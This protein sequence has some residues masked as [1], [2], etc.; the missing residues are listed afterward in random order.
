MSPEE[1][2]AVSEPALLQTLATS[3]LFAGAVTSEVLMF[4]LGK[5]NQSIILM[6]LFA[7]WVLSPFAA[8]AWAYRKFGKRSGSTKAI[9]YSVIFLISVVS[10]VIYANPPARQPA[11]VFLLVPLA[12][13]GL[14]AIASLFAAK[15][16]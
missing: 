3:A 4:R 9:L 6:L 5:R 2:P 14:L 8:G 13:L 1:K 11:S 15:R 16:R 10:P 12:S 7:G